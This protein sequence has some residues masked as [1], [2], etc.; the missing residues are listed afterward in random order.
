MI[1]KKKADS[2]RPKWHKDTVN[3]R[4]NLIIIMFLKHLFLHDVVGKKGILVIY[5]RHKRQYW[6]VCNWPQSANNIRQMIYLEIFRHWNWSV[7][8]PLCQVMSK[9]M[10]RYWDICYYLQYHDSS[11]LENLCDCMLCCVIFFYFWLFTEQQRWEIFS[12]YAVSVSVHHVGTVHSVF[13]VLWL[14]YGSC[15]LCE[16]ILKMIL[17]LCPFLVAQVYCS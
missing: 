17:I 15:L 11:V 8:K 5:L 10:F 12:L 16:N 4:G 6:Y 14:W 13:S 7:K 1:T 2:Y 3:I 9:M